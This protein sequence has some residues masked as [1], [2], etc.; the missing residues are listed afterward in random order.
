MS[1]RIKGLK[2]YRERSWLVE[3]YVTNARTLVDIS[4]QCQVSHMTI[5]QWLDKHEIPTRPRG[6]FKGQRKPNPRFRVK[7]IEIPLEEYNRLIEI[8][9]KWRGKS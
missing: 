3:E 2:L 4:T 8:E 1:E 6:I 9:A 5:H 7:T